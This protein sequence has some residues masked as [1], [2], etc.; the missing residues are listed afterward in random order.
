MKSNI[1]Y[2]QARSV[3][4]KKISFK[5]AIKR[6]RAHRQRIRDQRWNTKMNKWNFILVRSFYVKVKHKCPILAPWKRSIQTNLAGPGIPNK[7]TTI[8]KQQYAFLHSLFCAAAFQLAHFRRK[9]SWRLP[10]VFRRS[11]VSPSFRVSLLAIGG[12]RDGNF[13]RIVYHILLLEFTTHLYCKNWLY[14][15]I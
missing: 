2:K 14:A 5:R 7:Q 3:H 8:N 10:L 12:R 6:M 11:Q 1:I 4:G 13:N 9:G 15:I